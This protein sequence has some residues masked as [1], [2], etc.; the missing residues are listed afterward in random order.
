MEESISIK[1]EVFDEGYEDTQG[2]I[3]RQGEILPQGNLI[4]KDEDDDGTKYAVY[5]Q[6]NASI[7]TGSSQGNNNDTNDQYTSV[8]MDANR[9]NLKEN[10]ITRTVSPQ[11]MLCVTSIHQKD[12]TFGETDMTKIKSTEQ[13]ENKSLNSVS[14]NIEP[15]QSTYKKLECCFCRKLFMKEKNFRSH[16]L[17]HNI[18]NIFDQQKKIPIISK[19]KVFNMFCEICNKG[20]AYKS[21]LDRHSVTHEDIKPYI[22]DGC[23]ASY[24][25]LKSLKEHLG[26]KHGDKRYINFR[27]RVKRF[28]CVKCPM[29]FSCE[30]KL[31]AHQVVH[32]DDKPF[33]C[34]KCGRQYKYMHSLTEHLQTHATDNPKKC[35]YCGLMFESRN[36]LKI[37]WAETAGDGI[38]NI[39]IKSHPCNICDKVFDSRY[40]LKRHM[41]S[42]T[43]ERKFECTVCGLRFKQSAH[44]KGHIATHERINHISI[45]KQQKTESLLNPVIPCKKCQYVFRTKAE[46]KSHLLESANDS[47]HRLEQTNEFRCRRC[48]KY[49][50]SKFDLES[51][52]RFHVDERE[53]ECTVCE[54]RFKKS[55]HL[56]SHMCTHLKLIDSSCSK[57]YVIDGT[58]KT[59]FECKECK[60]EFVTKQDLKMHILGRAGDDLHAQPELVTSYQC[61]ICDAVFTGNSGLHN[62]QRVHEGKKSVCK[63]CGEKFDRLEDLINHGYTHHAYK[64]NNKIS[65]REKCNVCFMEFNKRCELKV[66]IIESIGDGMHKTL[67]SYMSQGKSSSCEYCGKFVPNKGG[68]KLHILRSH[69]K[70]ENGSNNV[71]AEFQ[72]VSIPE[73]NGNVIRV[74]TNSEHD[75]D[76]VNQDVMPVYNNN[77][78]ISFDHTEIQLSENK[79]RYDCMSGEN[80]E[81]LENTKYQDDHTNLSQ[82]LKETLEKL[83]VNDRM[84]YTAEGVRYKCTQCP[85]LLKK[86][87]HVKIHMKIHEK[88]LKCVKCGKMFYYEKKLEDHVDNQYQC[89]M[90]QKRFC[91]AQEFKKHNREHRKEKIL[92]CQYCPKWFLAEVQFIQ[93]VSIHTGVKPFECKICKD[94]FKNTTG[95][96]M[97]M[98]RHNNDKR[99]LC[100]ICGKKFIDATNLKMH[101]RIHAEKKEI[102]KCDQCDKQYYYKESLNYHIKIQHKKLRSNCKICGKT[103]NHQV[104]LR[105]HERKHTGIK[106]FRCDVCGKKFLTKHF[107]QIHSI[108]HTKVKK[109]VCDICGNKFGQKAALYR[110]KK[111]V[112]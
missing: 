13:I 7:S 56:K 97:H 44:L 91:K 54:M 100:H 26:N 48:D 106:P 94:K 99:Y 30:S 14:E 38:H 58:E 108:V 86:M 27:A 34:N 79:Q 24:K 60:M 88:N 90:C 18:P 16:L 42:H 36:R 65:K 43:D 84:V 70:K 49:F 57:T 69:T 89:S 103:F 19:K 109:F 29:T 11:K 63:I 95:L 75:L 31:E 62:H 12:Y 98:R 50:D 77:H 45:T 61:E 37:H 40:G 74:H 46:L 17:T 39:N 110:H 10:E 59:L 105:I 104:S 25:Q 20:F 32:T 107:L 85:R 101:S 92:Q 8:T 23:G 71:D 15:G 51:H 82:H 53:H 2:I 64:E 73:N 68:M 72:T 87:A 5:L 33:T 83:V 102:Y 78:N 41:L 4:C 96:K 111:F 28:I 3:E 55:S 76:N 35:Q 80:V 81:I 93:H 22:C 1:R 66:H 21:D 6:N 9:I 112:H 52:N 67:N 47:I